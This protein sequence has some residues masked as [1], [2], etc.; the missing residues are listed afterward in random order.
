MQGHIESHRAGSGHQLGALLLLAVSFG[1]CTVPQFKHDYSSARLTLPVTV[2]ATTAVATHDQRPYVTSGEKQADYVGRFNAGF[3]NPFHIGTTSG[4]PLT[5][6]VTEAVVRSLKG[7]GAVV[8]KIGTTPRESETALMS[9]LAQSGADRQL[10]IVLREW[11]TLTYNT[12][13]LLY[14][15][16]LKVLSGSG[17]LLA[18]NRVQGEEELGFSAWDPKPIAAEEGPK[19][20]G[21]KLQQLL[22]SPDVRQALGG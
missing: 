13:N 2:R 6:E 21:K 8:E 12:V 10:L 22:S 4:A 18:T 19:A 16:E 7:G 20:L 11:R 17:G 15:I 5:S 3:G 14:D 9:K 1:G